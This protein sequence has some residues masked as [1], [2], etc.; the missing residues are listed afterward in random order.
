MLLL[1]IHPKYLKTNTQT[2]TCTIA[3][4]NTIHKNQT[5][6][7]A[8]IPMVEWINKLWYLYM[9]KYY[10]E[11]KTNELLTHATMWINLQNT[12]K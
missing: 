9:V 7:R 8:Q 6:K 11:I 5:M 4:S 1:G 10:P 2:G 12:V 3:H